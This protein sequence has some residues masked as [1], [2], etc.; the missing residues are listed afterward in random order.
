MAGKSRKISFYRLSIDKKEPI[1]GSRMHRIIALSNEEVE[2]HF[3]M[4][5][6]NRMHSLSNGRKA[7]QVV[8]LSL[9]HI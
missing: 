4:I 5:Y 6:D 7:M 9:I 3:K 2:N 8:A 1:A